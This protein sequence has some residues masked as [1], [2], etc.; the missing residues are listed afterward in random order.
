MKKINL[1]IR[2]T[3]DSGITYTGSGHQHWQ[4]FKVFN[5]DFV[6]DEKL[7]GRIRKRI[8]SQCPYCSNFKHVIEQCTHLQ[9]G[10][11][12]LLKE[13]HI[14]KGILRKFFFDTSIFI[15]VFSIIGII[16][17]I[18]LLVIDNSKDNSDLG[19]HPNSFYLYII[20]AIILITAF[21]IFS[22]TAIQYLYFMIIARN[23][24]F[25]IR[26]PNL[27]VIKNNK[28]STY[29]L[30]TKIFLTSTHTVN[31]GVNVNSVDDPSNRFDKEML[32]KMYKLDGFYMTESLIEVL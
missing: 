20:I 3:T 5:C 26:L 27:K 6:P 8:Q 25:L 10:G 22:I 11:N 4:K 12:E 14:V 1:N 31:A 13:K 7:L 30:L 16:F 2:H 32:Y 18:A 19:H 17:M 21:L 9:I 29:N 28:F 23:K 24:Q 15:G